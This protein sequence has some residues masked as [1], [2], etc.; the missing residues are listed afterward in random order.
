MNNN[1]NDN[2]TNLPVS[3]GINLKS[4]NDYFQTNSTEVSDLINFSDLIDQTTDFPAINSTYSTYFKDLEETSTNNNYELLKNKSEIDNITYTAHNEVDYI[5]Y[6]LT[7]KETTIKQEENTAKTEPITAGRS[8]SIPVKKQEN[9]HAEEIA[10][11]TIEVSDITEDLSEEIDD[12]S[13]LLTKINK[14][15][16][17]VENPG[18]I[19]INSIDDTLRNKEL[20][21]EID[22]ENTHDI[23]VFGVNKAE[24]YYNIDKQIYNKRAKKTLSLSLN[25]NI[26]TGITAPFFAAIIPVLLL[27]ISI[28]IMSSYFKKASVSSLD[29]NLKT[30]TS[31]LSRIA[32]QKEEEAKKMKMV[33][34]E[35]LRKVSTERDKI[36]ASINEELNKR[37]IEIEN[38]YRKKLQDLIA[39]SLPQSE[40]LKFK[41]LLDIEKATALARAESEKTTKLSEQDKILVQKNK[42]IEQAKNQIQSAIE[43]KDFELQKIRDNLSQR[44]EEKN[45]ERD[46]VT[47][48]LDELRLYND[49]IKDF[50]SKIF[51]L[52]SSSIED[53]KK[54]NNSEGITKL[55]M[56]IQF[57]DSQ[58]SFVLNEPSLRD[59]MTTDIFMINTISSL[60][61]A[62]QNSVYYDAEFIKT[63]NKFKTMNELYNSAEESY[64][65]KK[66]PD[67]MQ[68]YGKVLKEFDNVNSSYLRISS[69][70]KEIQNARALNSYNDAI[71]NLRAG[72]YENALVL[73][74]QVIKESPNSDY[75]IQALDNITKL[76]L[77][78]NESGKTKQIEAQATLIYENAISLQKNSRYREALAEFEKVIIQYPQSGL[79]KKSLDESINI[80]EI[81]QSRE[82]A[83]FEDRLRSRF[84]QNYKN[85]TDSYKAGDL[86][87]ARNFYFAALNTAFNLYANE[88]V[89]DFI[90]V[91]NEYIQSLLK[92]SSSDTSVLSEKLLEEAKASIEKK[93]S[94]MIQTKEDEFNAKLAEEI[95]RS[96]L[97]RDE[98]IKQ[99]N[100]KLDATT[101]DTTQIAS[102]TREFDQR[103]AEKDAIIADLKNAKPQVD[104]KELESLKTEYET[105]LA[106]KNKELEELK[107]NLEDSKSSTGDELENLKKEYANK[108]KEI[109][110]GK[111]YIQSLQNQLLDSYKK[112]EEVKQNSEEMVK[113][114]NE[115]ISTELKDIKDKYTKLEQQSAKSRLNENELR[116]QITEEIKKDYEK[117]VELEK[118]R[119]QDEFSNEINKLK[120]TS[121]ID[122]TPKSPS[123]P[124]EL[125]SNQNKIS[126]RVIESIDSSVTFQFLSESMIKDLSVG[127]MVKV[128]R[129]SGGTEKEIA[130]IKITYT[131]GYS[132]FGRGRI[133]EVTKGEK[134]QMTDIIKK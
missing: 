20:D 49:K 23:D 94:E 71:S 88:S 39:Q 108:E 124:V 12:V 35:E 43:N 98:L 11:N 16:E 84:N 64:A 45:K 72:N 81:L 28:P 134:I 40:F 63:L 44:L 105:K 70:E 13:Y 110:D 67:A 65:S 86:S 32:K 41:K 37:R 103:L 123:G 19:D 116:R 106:E 133:M 31:I 30:D 3:K 102:I 83:Q 92:S 10:E 69:I 119:L 87:A 6:D 111:K 91:E 50:N 117:T 5:L 26:S 42:E 101:N 29:E 131:S 93:Y 33:L 95:N 58:K 21:T 17:F 96:K 53:F 130:K 75:T 76:S 113:T 127:D 114:A 112:N 2:F 78:L 104:Q 85:F 61:K 8:I 118:E 73:L 82:L 74:T 52:V 27:L 7:K 9:H 132:L 24:I 57:Y 121:G 77:L 18:L 89:N 68:K 99:Y 126:A 25:K 62:S 48:R 79:T 97:E 56:V 109:E 38:I 15:N 122:S 46:E 90:S 54:N 128:V 125:T 80:R 47:K 59:R 22:T 107:K 66:F 100:E 36:E 60:V 1:D 129:M 34:E 120:D 55:N 4:I 14:T 51:Q 115:K